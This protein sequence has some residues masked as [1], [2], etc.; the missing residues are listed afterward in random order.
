MPDA[1]QML[2]DDHREVQDMF[3]QFDA[4]DDRAEKKM[5]ADK[6]M[7]ELEIHS[8]LE[9]EIFYPAVRKQDD[10]EAD[11]MNEAMEEH[12]VVDLLIGEIRARRSADDT[13]VAKFTV[14]AEMVKHHIEEEETEM[15][16]K[17][18]E[19]GQ[20]RMAQ[21]GQQMEKRKLE[22]MK[23]AQGA[24]GKTSIRAS[25]N[26][27]SKPAT[28]KTATATKRTTAKRTTSTGARSGAAKRTARKTSTG[29]ARGRTGSSG[30]SE[31]RKA[32]P[33]A[34]ATSSRAAS[35]RKSVPATSRARA[36]AP[37]R[38]KVAAKP[39]ARR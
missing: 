18:A 15:L 19:E 1:L 10:V 39:S 6:A 4:T 38:R 24:R 35:P 27:A 21:L 14:L 2:R 36:A 29:T 5:I 30:R 12:H 33:R 20:E 9:E 11:M 17:A 16:P 22:L 34:R 3:K 7:M 23:K 26:G 25:A 28:R 37:S 13:F 31:A 8:Q 32:A